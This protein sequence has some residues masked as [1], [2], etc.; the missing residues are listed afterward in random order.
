MLSPTSLLRRVKKPAKSI[1]RAV[2][3]FSAQV[4]GEAALKTSP[5]PRPF[6]SRCAG[7]GWRKRVTS[8][9]KEQL[10][11]RVWQ[12]VL[13]FLQV[14]LGL[15]YNYASGPDRNEIPHTNAST[16]TLYTT[17]AKF[18]IL[19]LVKLALC[20]TV[21]Y[22]E[23][24]KNSQ[25]QWTAASSS[26]ISSGSSP[27]SRTSLMPADEEA[28]TLPVR[29]TNELWR[30]DAIRH[31]HGASSSQAL[32]FGTAGSNV[33]VGLLAS[34]LAL[35]SYLALYITSSSP[36]NSTLLH[37]ASIFAPPLSAAILQI[38][39]GW[40]A[41]FQ[42]WL[43]ALLQILGLLSVES[44]SNL[45]DIESKS[46]VLILF[47][48]LS[49]SLFC[50]TLNAVYKQHE[51]P[52][53]NILT[54]KLFS[55]G[56]LVHLVILI[57]S[58]IF[59]FKP[60]MSITSHSSFNLP[61]LAL[62]AIVDIAGINLISSGSSGAVLFGIST[63]LS[64][65]I[66]LGCSR[67]S[68]ELV[69]IGTVCGLAVAL[70]GF[71]AYWEAES[72]KQDAV[73]M[74][75]PELDSKKSPSVRWLLSAVLLSLFG[76]ITYIGCGLS[77]RANTHSNNLSL[78]Q[79]VTSNESRRAF[80]DGL[81]DL[82]YFPP[83]LPTSPVSPPA[84]APIEIIPTR[85]PLPSE[86]FFKGNR[87][88]HEFDDVLLIVFFSHARYDINL[89]YYKEV[90]A[91]FFPNMVFVGPKS[92]ED[93]GFGH[94]YD[95]L[96]DSYE[97]DE[98]ISD[99]KNYKM[100]G[101]MAHHM[102]YTVLTTPPYSTNNYTGYLWAPFD[103]LLNV[104]RLQKFNQDRIW[105]FSPWGEYVPNRAVSLDLWS[106]KSYHAPPAR[107]SPDP[108]MDWNQTYRGWWLDW[109]WGDPHY[110]IPVCKQAFERVSRV[111]R[112]RMARRFTNNKTRYIGGSA[113]TLYIP[114]RLV[115]EFKDLLGTFLNTSCFLEVA[116]PT[117]VHL[118]VPEDE[119]ILFVDHVRMFSLIFPSVELN[120]FPL[121]CIVY[122][123]LTSTP[124]FNCIRYLPSQWWI[125]KPPF[126][127]SFVR[128]RWGKGME[129]DTFHTFHWGDKGPDGVWRA[130]PEH[131]EDV[132]SLFRES[133]KRQSVWW[134]SSEKSSSSLQSSG[135][136]R[137]GT[138]RLRGSQ[139][140]Q[141][142]HGQS[143]PSTHS[144]F[145]DG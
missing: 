106:N 100:A 61:I 26:S 135:V 21:I 14:V 71:Y 97:S 36:A 141:T 10:I 41:S 75:S 30:G 33:A 90:Y 88:Y 28:P 98:D 4:D 113:D 93:K 8:K 9:P 2:L 58:N 137:S 3:L 85:V 24:R 124:H 49:T 115:D 74:A 51:T 39:T 108:E 19:D 121:F 6:A 110:G 81:T 27:S 104:P 84:L 50:I 145:T 143:R 105:Y 114:A 73:L 64:A 109:W 5:G 23:A 17:S 44:Q 47:I 86:Q 129:V 128:D 60:P 18:A 52:I 82:A 63:S 119:D 140:T 118:L 35:N 83:R 99:W 22:F 29:S 43:G 96:V 66:L 139:R 11:F 46:F 107:I 32:L 133:A 38:S 120:N 13:V 12:I 125:W 48:A 53:P 42:Q 80:Y 40:K 132:R 127:A 34:L 79:N 7:G 142:K 67:I 70:L 136:Y 56:L 131:I 15:T 16:S 72:G 69:D 1:G 87:T 77:P 65:S 112:R 102:L 45:L 117:V 54:F 55:F 37:L 57:L 126:N 78:Q 62:C 116:V 92:R 59:T 31:V 95:V 91:E 130:I 138:E 89:D 94:S 20:G 103:M 123:L 101:R 134:P 111:R 68:Y 25:S 144:A 122:G 76:I